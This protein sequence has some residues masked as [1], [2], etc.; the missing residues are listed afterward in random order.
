MPGWI[1]DALGRFDALVSLSHQTA[2]GAFGHHREALHPV[3]FEGQSVQICTLPDLG[4]LQLMEVSNRDIKAEKSFRGGK[5]LLA[6]S[7]Q[8]AVLVTGKTSRDSRFCY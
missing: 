1:G 2:E 6:T 5:Y 3:G 8:K 4:R 7:T